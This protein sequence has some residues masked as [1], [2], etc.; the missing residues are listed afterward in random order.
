MNMHVIDP[1]QNKK[2]VD[3]PAD[4]TFKAIFRNKD[5]N[6]LVLINNLLSENQIQ[7]N[8]STKASSGGKFVSFTITANFPSEEKLQDICFKISLIANY[9]TLF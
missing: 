8:I 1:E 4:V 7:G 5:E 2:Q 3:Y 6:S 9:M